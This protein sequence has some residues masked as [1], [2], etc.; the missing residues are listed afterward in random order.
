MLGSQRLVLGCRCARRRHKAHLR[1][2]QKKK[3]GNRTST[4]IRHQRIHTGAIPPRYTLEFPLL[5]CCVVIP[6]ALQHREDLLAALR[7]RQPPDENV[8]GAIQRVEKPETARGF[9]QEG[10]FLTRVAPCVCGCVSV[11]GD[12]PLPVVFNSYSE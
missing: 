3:G 6:G 1:L 10:Q 8:D 5:T 12:L 4:L 2:H 9:A 7:L 11:Q